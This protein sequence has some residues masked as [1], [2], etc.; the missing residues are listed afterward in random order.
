MSFLYCGD[1]DRAGFDIFCRLCKEA[2]EL[3]IELFA[4]IYKKMLELA[5]VSSL[6]GSDDKRG[7][8]IETDGLRKL[9]SDEETEKINEILSADKRLPQEIIN[10]EVLKNNSR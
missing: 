3:D 8:N 10:Y 1:I 9:F 5:D 6:P 4:P 2:A 7:K